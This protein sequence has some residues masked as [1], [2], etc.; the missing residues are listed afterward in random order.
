ME[1]LQRG[2]VDSRMRRVVL[3]FFAAQLWRQ[4]AVLSN[5]CERRG[6]EGDVER[7]DRVPILDYFS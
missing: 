5:V 6:K 2:I 7:F 4:G 3:V 1:L